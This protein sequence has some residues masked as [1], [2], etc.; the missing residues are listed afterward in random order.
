MDYEDGRTNNWRANGIAATDASLSITQTYDIIDDIPAESAETII[1]P[2]P[3]VRGQFTTDTFSTTSTE[4]TIT[5]S[6]NEEGFDADRTLTVTG[7]ST[8]AED[9]MSA[10]VESMDYTIALAGTAFFS[11]TD[12]TWTVTH[13]TT[14]DA[15]FVAA[16]DREGTVSF[17]TSDGNNSTKTF[18]LTIAGDDLNEAG[19]TFSVQVSVADAT[20]DG[21]T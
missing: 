13:G 1:I 17:G 18:T 16:S 10:G 2:V 15:D 8:I 4:I 14:A 20:A 11:A 5:I 9:D 3:T 21:G 7:P 19:E 12:V 6:Q